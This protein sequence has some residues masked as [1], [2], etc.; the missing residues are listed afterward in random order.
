MPNE[1]ENDHGA[2][3]PANPEIVELDVG[4]AD[5]AEGWIELFPTGGD[6]RPA[7]RAV[8]TVLTVESVL[9]WLCLL[10]LAGIEAIDRTGSSTVLRRAAIVVACGTF[11]F[12]IAQFRRPRLFTKRVRTRYAVSVVVLVGALTCVGGGAAFYAITS[13][14]GVVASFLLVGAHWLNAKR[15]CV[16]TWAAGLLAVVGAVLPIAAALLLSIG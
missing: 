11:F 7:L 8:Y 1:P 13:G 3:E 12:Q 14:S 6:L 9:L 5:D 10:A 4:S 15:G 16:P 2:T